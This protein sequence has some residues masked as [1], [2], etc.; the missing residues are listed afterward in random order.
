VFPPQP[1]TLAQAP[2]KTSLAEVERSH[3]ER[4]LNEMGGNITHAAQALGIDRR[5]LQRK[6]KTYG[7]DAD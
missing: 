6:L 4:V 5:T 7:I 1:N 3:I 2:G